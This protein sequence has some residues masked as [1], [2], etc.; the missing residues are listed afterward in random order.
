MLQDVAGDFEFHTSVCAMKKQTQRNNLPDKLVS[1]GDYELQTSLIRAIN[2]ASPDGILVVDEKGV[3]ISH[4]H[5]FVDVWRIPRGH[6]RGREQGTAIGADDTPILSTVIKR[7]K[8]PQAFL[9]RVRELY[10]NPHL[11]DHCEI[12]LFDGRTLERHSTVLRSEDDRYLGRVWFFR[13]ITSQKQTE[14]MLKE[15]THL[16]PLTGIA[17]RRYFFERSS[18]EFARTKRHSTPLSIV[19][20]DID[21]FKQINDSYGHAVG[22]EVLKSLCN[23][24]QRLLRVVDVFA[25]IGGEEFAVLLPDTNSEGA[26]D[27]AERLR[28]EIAGHKFPLIGCEVHCTIS[29]GVA[30]LRSTDTCVEDC[31]LR[32]DSAMYRAKEN[33]RNRVEI[34][35]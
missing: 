35:E 18:Q 14:A 21:L 13:D 5:R 8:D 27:Q 28:Q 29:I 11:T 9:A 30:T 19:E 33:G 4:N 10:D 15:L 24:S 17:N 3:I 25:R 32:A 2:E 31:L 20:F 7:V 22:D 34:E 6:L 23:R 16:D 12:E 26:A 1:A